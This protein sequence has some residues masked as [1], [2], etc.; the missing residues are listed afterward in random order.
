MA[1]IRGIGRKIVGGCLWPQACATRHSK[2]HSFSEPLV[3]PTKTTTCHLCLLKCILRRENKALTA[4]FYSQAVAAP[5]PHPI[6]AA[7]ASGSSPIPSGC[8]PRGA[9]R[10][11]W[12]PFFVTDGARVGGRGTN[13]KKSAIPA[14]ENT[15]IYR[16]S[17]PIAL[18]AVVSQWQAQMG[19]WWIDPAI[20]QW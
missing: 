14:V 3:G 8:I 19:S 7:A 13:E 16:I 20:H 18:V 2:T 17:S 4:K 12:A 15:V 11:S 6:G 1:R 10:C 9:W 5:L